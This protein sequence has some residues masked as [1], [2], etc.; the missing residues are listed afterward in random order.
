MQPLPPYSSHEQHWN[1]DKNTVF[2]NHGSFGSCPAAILEK[3]YQLK[4]QIEKDPVLAMTENFES[5]YHENKEA[6][7][8][9]TGCDANDLVLIKNTTMGV[10]TILQ[11]LTFEEGDEILTHSHAYGA[12][13]NVLKYYA[14]LNKCKLI[15]ADIPFPIAHEDELTRP[16][17]NAVTSKTKLVLLDHITSATGIIFPVEK[18]TQQ[19]ESRGI[20][21][22]IDGAH[23]PGMVDLNIA[24]IGAS[25]YTGNCHKWICSPRGSALLHV[26]K[27]KQHKIRPL[28]ISH[29]HDLYS[30]TEKHWSAQFIWPGT[31][32]YSAYFLIKDSIHYMQSILG[33]WEALRKNNRNL[34][35]EARKLICEELQIEIPTPEH[36]IGHLASIPV[37][38]HPDAPSK[39]FN[40]VAPLKKQL[41]EEYKIQVPVFYFH[42]K[43]PKLLL[44]IST[45][46][47]N[48][49]EQYEYLAAC[50]KKLL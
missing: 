6:L 33:S 35:L 30:G 28:Q 26:R 13:V 5:V 18:L 1:H 20:E 34:C 49:G 19:L 39:F 44:R 27:D 38:N 36:L 24:A 17:L 43:N 16:L 14:E 4:I 32:D 2:L 23:A 9:F 45:Q 41:M 37:R 46:V 8:K 10:N 40:M 50:M 25:Y 48:S 3:Q 31:D 7:A 21:V 22:L 47:Y 15:I 42:N 11:S 12:C 29:Y